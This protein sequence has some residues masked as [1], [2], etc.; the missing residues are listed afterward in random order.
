M[1]EDYSLSVPPFSALV[2]HKEWVGLTCHRPQT[3][4]AGQKLLEQGSAGTHVLALVAGLVKVVRT[5]RD[6]RRWL[7]AFRGPGEILGEMALQCGGE[8]MA[9]VWAM[10]DCKVSVV[11]ADEFQRFIRE[12]QLAYPLSKMA[13]NRLKEQTEVR[14]G[15]VHERLAVALLRLV[16]VSGGQSSFSLTREDLAQ[17]IDVGRKAVSKAL[18]RLGPDRVKAGKSRIDV[19]SVKRLRQTIGA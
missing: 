14:E 16:E 15:A 7:L 17:H 11:F 6:G 8:R 18:E 10:S 13:S 3:Y 5:G 9:T 12:H 19:I 2:P 1:S 4:L